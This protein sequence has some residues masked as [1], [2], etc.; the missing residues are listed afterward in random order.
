MHT[1]IFG[2]FCLTKGTCLNGNILVPG[3]RANNF[4]GPALKV[5][6]GG[7]IGHGTAH[8]VTQPKW[9]YTTTPVD[10]ISIIM[11]VVVYNV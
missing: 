3:V 5:Y 1:H 10:M 2:K 4:S 11:F 8:F 7:R 9:S 6:V